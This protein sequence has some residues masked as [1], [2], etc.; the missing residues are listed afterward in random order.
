MCIK[1]TLKAYSRYRVYIFILVCNYWTVAKIFNNCK[2]NK[3]KL[4]TKI[5]LVQ[6]WTELMNDSI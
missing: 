5:D 1:T 3:L 4:N 6:F 2:L